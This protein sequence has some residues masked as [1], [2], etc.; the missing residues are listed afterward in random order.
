MTFLGIFRLFMKKYLPLFLFFLILS[1]LFSENSKNSLVFKSDFGW[2]WNSREFSVPLCA[3]GANFAQKNSNSFVKIDGGYFSLSS[4]FSKFNAKAHGGFFDFAGGAERFSA[5]LSYFCAT[6]PDETHIA[7]GKPRFILKDIFANFLIGGFSYEFS[8]FVRFGLDGFFGDIFVSEGDLYYFYG[9]ISFPKAFGGIF[10][11]FLPEDFALKT[12]VLRSE[13]SVKTNENVS[14]GDGNL[15]GFFFLAQKDFSFFDAH[16]LSFLLGYANLNFDAK[17]SVTNKTQV[18]AFFPY[19]YLNANADGFYH[20]LFTGGDYNF[21]TRH[22]E[23]NTR[24][25]FTILHERITIINTKKI[26]FLTVR[27]T[28]TNLRCPI[29]KNLRLFWVN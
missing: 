24:C 23:L 25:V 4:D 5:N 15:G 8:E 9:K 28:R 7:D 18:Y 10:S 29:L 17:I 27:T 13:I 6:F 21:R 14:L 11:V 19:T 20:L 3:F 1:G 12:G 16:S 26:F 22:S 2:I